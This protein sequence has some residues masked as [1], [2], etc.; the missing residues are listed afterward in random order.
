M[1]RI[2]FITVAVI[3]LSATCVPASAQ[4]PAPGAAPT[5]MTKSTLTRERL[6][7][8]YKNWK[9]DKPKLAN[10]RKQV[11][12]K[13]LVDDDRWFFISDCMNKP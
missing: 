6:R 1:F 2:S 9:R 4:T 5:A 8:M 13:G 12:A 7:E 10:C 3:V 11:K